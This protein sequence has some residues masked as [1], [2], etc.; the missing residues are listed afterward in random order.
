KRRSAMRR[1][2]DGFEQ[3]VGRML[4]RISN[5]GDSDAESCRDGPLRNGFRRVIGSLCVNIGAEGFEQALH[6]LFVEDHH[7]IDGAKSGD[8]LRARLLTEDRTAW[9]FERADAAVPIDAHSENV[10]FAT[11]PFE[12]ADVPDMERVEAAVRKND[13][14]AAALVPDKFCSQSISRNDFGFRAAHASGGRSPRFTADGFEEL[15]AGDS[16]SAAFHHNQA[17]G[18]VGDVGGL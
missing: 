3:P 14:L 16:R 9:A 12:V 5:D 2:A 4:F 17:T 11:S 15:F 6:A 1:L 18:D 7:V 8:E 13:T 10:T